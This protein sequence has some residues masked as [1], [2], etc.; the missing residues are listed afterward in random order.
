MRALVTVAADVVETSEIGPPVTGEATGLGVP[1]RKR[2]RV[3][4]ELGF[5]PILDRGVTVATT[6]RG[7]DVVRAD[8]ATAAIPRLNI[9]TLLLMTVQA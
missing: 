2:D 3:Y 8:V 6:E 9:Q 1:T 5:V 7:S 4:G